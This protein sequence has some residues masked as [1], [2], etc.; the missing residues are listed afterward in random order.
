MTKKRIAHN[1]GKYSW[2]FEKAKFLYLVEKKTFKELSKIF[3]KSPSGF[4]RAF[5]ENGIVTRS[6]SQA[7]RGHVHSDETKRK[8]GEANS[9]SLK[10]NIPA[11]YIDGRSKL[12]GPGRYGSDW[13]EIR[14]EV[15]KRDQ[16]TCQDCGCKMKGKTPHHVH[17]I[18]PFVESNDNSLNNLVLLCASCHRT[19]EAQIMR[20]RKEAISCE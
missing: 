7:L 4:Y 9:I 8:I 11:N 19:V 15:Y 18:N 1:K 5:K 20:T 2:D 17:H 16:Y 10:G 12:L 13:R 3:E 6:S 14:V